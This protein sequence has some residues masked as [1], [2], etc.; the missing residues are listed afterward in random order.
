VPWACLLLLL[1]AA[2]SEPG[3]PLSVG[4][5][6]W[7][8]FATLYYARARGK[9]DTRA[10]ELVDF[11]NAREVM[12]AF[13]QGRIDAAG[14]TLDEA[15][16]LA[17]EQGGMRIVMV[18]DFSAGG[19]VL[20]ARPPISTLQGLRGKRVGV[21]AEAEGEYILS[22]ILDI[23]RLRRE[24]IRV[25]DLPLERHLEAYRNREVD[26]VITFDPVRIE[27]L[28]AGARQ[29]F[30]SSEIA[31]E[32]MDVLVVREEAIR[33]RPRTLAALVA[34]HFRAVE[35]FREN[36]AG[37]AQMVA[38]RFGSASAVLESWRL[39]EFQ[40]RVANE[41]LLGDGAI[42]PVI[43]QVHAVVSRTRPQENEPDAL[44]L[45]DDRFVRGA[46]P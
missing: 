13:R 22:R 33:K 43:K 25:V 34:G 32:I 19:D 7:P 44:A 38:A 24:D 20:L 42:R 8:G 28:S 46:R 2:C 36:P 5:Y 11:G 40:G 27:L 21:E 1:L 12:A 14:M 35:D 6:S 15:L 37:A 3:P 41:R 23:A 26:A 16:R 39:I 29:L 10:V 4:I 30:S 31:S 18:F 17:A 9:L 45:V